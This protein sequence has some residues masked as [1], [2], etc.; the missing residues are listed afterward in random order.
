MVSWLP[1]RSWTISRLAPFPAAALLLVLVLAAGASAQ[2]EELGDGSADPVR[3]FER[4]QNAHAHG[5]F[6]LALDLYEQAIKLR[7]EFPEA[8]FKRGS[9]LISLNRLPEAEVALRR[10]IELRKDWALPYASLGVLLV[11]NSRDREAEPVLRQAIKLDSQNSIALRSLAEVRLRAGDAREAVDL[12][13]RVTADRDAPVSAW[14][15]RAMT[16]RAL[17]DKASA[18]ISLDHALQSEPENVAGLVERSDL[19]A[20]EADYE[21]AIEDLKTAERVKPGD[22]QILSRLLDL[23]QRAGKVDDASRL[24]QSLGIVSPAAIASSPGEIKVVGTTAEIEAA[25]DADPLKA[26]QALEN[27]LQKNPRN[28]MLLARLGASYRTD[29]PVRSLDFYRRA[30]ELD[31]KNPEYATGY[32]AALVQSRR[33]GEAAN[34]LRQ[35]ISTKPDNFVAHANLATALYELK[36]FDEALPEYKWLLE[37]KPEL[38]VSYYFIATA[39]DKLGEFEDALAS[40]E[41][42]L[43]RADPKVN[44]LEIEKV[45]LRLP[46]LKRQI[47]LGQ[48]VKHKQ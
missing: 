14:I 40:Y 46:P 13:K 10:S 22:R 2:T 15:L 18:K 4:G 9:T 1:T 45:K 41:V 6:A 16:E 36:R 42:F 5:D 48:G 35:V 8:E 12:A 44:E 21:H 47:K 3:L 39:Q 25:N 19:R 31:P 11:R 23:Y 17:G 38:V 30:N 7:P 27:L 24:A 33:F 20:A 34:I 32:A 28:A 43:S 29:D 37:A 26:R